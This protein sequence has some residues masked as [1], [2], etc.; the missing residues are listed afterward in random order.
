[1]DQIAR[2]IAATLVRTLVEELRLHTKR[3]TSLPRR[4]IQLGNACK[5]NNKPSTIL[6]RGVR[7]P[8]CGEA[9]ASSFAPP[10]RAGNGKGRSDQGTTPSLPL[11]CK[12]VGNFA[13][14]AGPRGEMC[15]PFRN[16]LQGEGA[17]KPTG[18]HF[19]SV[20]AGCP[21][22]GVLVL[23]QGLRRAQTLLPTTENIHLEDQST[24]SESQGPARP[25]NQTLSIRK[26]WSPACGHGK[27][28]KMRR[29]QQED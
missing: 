4:P 10:R 8:E 3:R 5:R 24:R 6:A 14:L 25:G 7:G 12:G 13:P 15:L 9:G 27:G 21:G 29:P 1:M 26:T 28:G 18:S 23:P 2:R 11:P 22:S 19:V 20:L 16:P 17:G